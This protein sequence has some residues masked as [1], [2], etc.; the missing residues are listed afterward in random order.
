VTVLAAMGQREAGRIPKAIRRP[1]YDFG[2][3]RER[4][5][6]PRADARRQ[7]K[8]GKVDGTALGR[9]RERA[10]QLTGEDVAGSHIVMCRHHEVGKQPLRGR[11]SGSCEELRDDTVW[12]EVRQ[13]L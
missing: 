5:N 10:V 6:R 4:S 8:V 13:Q 9:R 11:R 3:H 2:D 1:V 7:Q 12:T